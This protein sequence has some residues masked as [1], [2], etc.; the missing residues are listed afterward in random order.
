MNRM[1]IALALS[2]GFSMT[3]FAGVK[4]TSLHLRTDG[5]NGFIS[6]AVNGRSNELPDIK[7]TKNIIEITLDKAEAFEA[8]AKNIS[9]AVL[10]ANTLN[11]KAIVKATLPYDV[12][13]DTVNLNWKN[14]NIEVS[15]PRNRGNKS[16]AAVVAPVVPAVASQVA[17]AI[18]PTTTPVKEIKRPE[19]KK[20]HLN[21]DYLNK[22]MNEEKAPIA[23]ASPKA[24]AAP[25]L[26]IK[27]DEIKVQQAAIAK[28]EVKRTGKGIPSKST[29]NFSF[30]GYAL[31]FTVFLALVLGLF[32]GVVQLL[33]K[34]V[35][36]RGKLG[37]LNNGQMIQVLSTT[38]VSPKRSLMI[39]K[40]H[41][42]IF[43]VANSESGLEFL[44]EMKDTSGLIK[45]GEKLVTGSNFDLNFA[46][47]DSNTN[48]EDTNI[49][50]KENIL[51]STP[52]NDEKGISK[53][54]VAKD[55]VKF[56]DE[57]KKKA[58]KLKPIEFN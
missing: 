31:K 35:F 12:E 17:F 9:G 37:F 26:E 24:P 58:R 47:A 8:I 38:Y 20:D 40:A 3:A 55:I 28:P 52:V 51:E 5:P 10:T 56:S 54:A 44:S 49:K 23:A 1:F 22:L 25:A 21:E 27:K 33:K 13:A 42:Q 16:S 2:L 7:V 36:S 30:A 34:G 29:D 18:T 6:V 57:L 32:Y 46:T 48:I 50:L 43:L 14:N 53:L 11:G 15:F 41:K 39:V 19:I 45:E 4:V